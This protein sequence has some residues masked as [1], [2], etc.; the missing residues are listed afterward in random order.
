M[1]KDI[2]NIDYTKAT[3]LLPVEAQILSQYQLL[4]TQLKTLNNEIHNL[5]TSP[6]Q[7]ASQD[8]NSAEKLLDNLRN[9]EM[10]IGLVYTLFK[11]AVYLLFLQNE[12]DR[13]LKDSDESQE[14]IYSLQHDV[15]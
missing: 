8:S 1:S 10:K 12:E 15:D 9:L 2:Y 4:A 6:K 7:L 14:E 13:N 11:G 5:N 3:S